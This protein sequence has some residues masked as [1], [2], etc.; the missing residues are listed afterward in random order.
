MGKN[1][2]SGAEVDAFPLESPKSP[3]MPVIPRRFPRIGS[4]FQTRIAKSSDPLDRP[5]PERMSVEYP[6]VTEIEV[7]SSG[8]SD[9][10]DGKTGYGKFIRSLFHCAT[11]CQSRVFSHCS[12][13]L[14]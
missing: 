8:K 12:L 1:T 13:S 6:Y 5:L 2:P 11:N 10:S 4:Q 9:I 3:D 7:L 14:R